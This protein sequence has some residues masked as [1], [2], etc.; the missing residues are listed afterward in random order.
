MGTHP[1][2]G[3]P[4]IL[5]MDSSC[6]HQGHDLMTEGLHIRNDASRIMIEEIKPEHQAVVRI[7]PGPNLTTA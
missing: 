5:Q 6:L 7:K 4:E 1:I 2:Q 3:D